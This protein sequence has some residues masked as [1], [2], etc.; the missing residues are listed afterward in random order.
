MP[1][2]NP[3]DFPGTN[4]GTVNGINELTDEQ[5]HAEI[6]KGANNRFGSKGLPIL[7]ASQAQRTEETRR[8]E[9]EAERLL[10]EEANQIALDALEEAK[11]ANKKAD[12]ARFWSG[13]AV[14]VT[15]LLAA[16]NILSEGN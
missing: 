7:H 8:A 14:L 10:S 3:D 5:L 4:R 1:P 16:I 15:V 12:S 11:K 9:N 13:I 6:A 2:L